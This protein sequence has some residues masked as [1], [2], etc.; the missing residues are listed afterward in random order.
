MAK[1]KK[2]KKNKK[3]G[4]KY[5]SRSKQDYDRSSSESSGQFDA[6]IKDGIPTFKPHDGSNRIRVLPPTFD[7]PSDFAYTLSVHYGIGANE[8]TYL[9]R[10]MLGEDEECAICDEQKRLMKEGEADDAS[11]FKAKKRKATWL[12][13]RKADEAEKLNREAIDLARRQAEANNGEFTV[14]TQPVPIPYAPKLTRT[15]QGKSGLVDR[16]KWRLTD[17]NQVQIQY[18]IP[19]ETLLDGLAK[20]YHDTRP[21]DGIEFYNEPTLRV[22]K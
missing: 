19:N 17:I 7:D 14:E 11:S 16:W 4:F 12:I 3:T 15:D 10:K 2:T 18:L 13:D 5:Q 21:L 20:A 1:K 8:Q 22:S 6:Y 9:C